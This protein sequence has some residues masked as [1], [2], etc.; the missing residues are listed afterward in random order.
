MHTLT[1]DEQSLLELVRG[2]VVAELHADDGRDG[3]PR[4]RFDQLAAMDLTSLPFAAKDGGVDLPLRTTAVVVEELA[5]GSAAAG[6]GLATHLVGGLALEAA[7]V[8]QL[9]AEARERFRQV[10]LGERVAAV[11]MLA[12]HTAGGG[13]LLRRD[14]CRVF[15][16]GVVNGALIPPGAEQ[17]ITVAHDDA[18]ALHLLMVAIDETDAPHAPDAADDDTSQRPGPG[19]L[20]P[21]PVTDVVFEYAEF[22]GE[23]VIASGEQAESAVQAATDA[24]FLLASACAVGVA[25]SSI[26]D[27]LHAAGANDQQWAVGTAD[28]G[29]R[30]T[31]AVMAARTEAARALTRSAAERR[32]HA[33]GIGPHRHGP[34]AGSGYRFRRAAA[35][36]WLTAHTAATDD[37]RDLEALLRPTWSSAH[38]VERGLRALRS[39]TALAGSVAAARRDVGEDVLPGGEP[40]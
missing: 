25:F 8:D 9:P 19:P 1:A 4:Q 5:R 10:V 13:P 15:L 26:D 40:T 22:P 29:V 18:G 31:L 16:D 27:V 32:D 20:G 37:L 3:F 14:G 21:I 12:A 11:A 17:L 36:A 2:Y 35:A 7:G 38:A 23:V 30:I 39:L 34:E 33:R 24:A 28:A 6:A